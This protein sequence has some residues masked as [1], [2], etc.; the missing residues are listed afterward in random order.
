M[1]YHFQRQEIIHNWEQIFEIDPEITEILLSV[2]DTQKEVKA[3]LEKQLTTMQNDQEALSLIN[4]MK[5]QLA[6][7]GVTDEISTEIDEEIDLDKDMNNYTSQNIGTVQ[8]STQSSDISGLDK[9]YQPAVGIVSESEPYNAIKLP[10]E[11]GDV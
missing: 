11:E 7:A 5:Q 4:D 8:K 2:P 3:F 9:L 6:A 10:F 1:L